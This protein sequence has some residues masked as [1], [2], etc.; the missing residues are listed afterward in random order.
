LDKVKQALKAADSDIFE[1]E[2]NKEDVEKYITRKLD[3]KIEDIEET[4]KMTIVEKISLGVQGQYNFIMCLSNLL[5]F[6]WLS[7]N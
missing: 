1:I 3:E 4:L 7:S 5:D 2:A 6:C